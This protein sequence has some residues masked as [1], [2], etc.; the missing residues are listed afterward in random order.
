MIGI[1][2]TGKNISA[3]VFTKSLANFLDLISN[4][5]CAVSKQSK[6]SIRWEL[7]TLRKSSPA[8]VEFA[9]V[10]R[11]KANDYAQVV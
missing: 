8:I 7:L 9:A 10:P 2:L 4:I 6:G 3:D 11:S 5:D 1:R